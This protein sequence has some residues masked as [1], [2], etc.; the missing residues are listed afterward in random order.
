MALP[1]MRH[2]ARLVHAASTTL[3]SIV[4]DVLDVS[5]LEAG[6]LE[7]DLHP[8]LPRNLVEHAAMLLREQATA[9][10]LALHVEVDAEV[11]ASLLGDQA[12]LRQVLLNL[13]SNAVK[14]TAK[15][16]VW[17]RVDHE[18]QRDGLAQVRFTVGDT[19]IGIP[20]AK[21][22]RLFQR[23]SQVDGSTARQYGGTGLGLSICKSLIEM[24]GGSIRVESTEGEGSSFTFSLALPVAE[25]AAD[26]AP[27]G[28]SA[29][30]SAAEVGA[31]VLL[32]ED[33]AMNQELAVAMLTRWGHRVDVVADGAAAVDAVM[34]TRYDLV[35]MDVQ[36][37]GMDG[38]EATRRIRG[39]GGAHVRLPII[40]MTANVLPRDV[41]RCRL[42]GTDAHIG[43]PFVPEILRALVEHWAGQG[44]AAPEADPAAQAD[45]AEHD[46]TVLD[47]LR[48]MMGP[49]RLAIML[50]QF[51]A[52]LDSRLRQA[53]AD[54][55][56]WQGIRSDAHALIST[57]GMLGFNALS[58]AAR[59]LEQ[60]CLAAPAGGP[61]PAMQLERV[62]SEMAR[63]G[64]KSAQMIAAWEGRQAA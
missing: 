12:R 47:D 39:L 62:R 14:F 19:G 35:L 42:A 50:R 5:K 32:A 63:A 53:P 29:P 57:A 31:H 55:A 52:D 45:E 17:L 44:S 15:G 64:A 20:Q 33:V 1:T 40:A 18:G 26:V 36:M 6:S 2:H 38:L 60:A 37:P 43:K 13:L 23:F 24:M 56:G 59:S 7:L 3:L 22:H 9:K 51:V 41:E 49:A 8:F 27:P 48:E 46:A 58:E 25:A 34:R 16:M 21:R 28:P 54:A 30:S 10:G 4:N 11:P 61:E